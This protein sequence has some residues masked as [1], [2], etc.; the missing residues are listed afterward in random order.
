MGVSICE[1]IWVRSGPT[2]QIARDGARLV[3]NLNASPF[4]AGRQLE[5]EQIVGER[6]RATGVPVAYVNSVGGQDELI[7]DGGSMAV[8]T[9]GPQ[10]RGRRFAEDQVTFDLTVAAT[11]EPA[12]PRCGGEFATLRSTGPLG[13]RGPCSVTAGPR[14]TV[15]GALSGNVGLCRRRTGFTDV[16]VGLSGGV[17][18]AL[19]AALATDALGASHTHVVLMPSRFSTDHSVTDAMT[20]ARNLGIDSRTIPIEP[21]HRAFLEMLARRSRMCRLT[22][23]RRTCRA[24]SGGD[25]DGSVEQVLLVGSDHRQQE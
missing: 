14:G 3:L 1:D 7:F 17:D 2:E 15:G 16:A 20:L 8:T 12:P 21:A 23:P 13:A 24:G 19:V 25:P 18:S 10:A 22:S 9:D 5:R 6:V 11:G 4:R